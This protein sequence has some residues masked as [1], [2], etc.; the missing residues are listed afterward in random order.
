MTTPLPPKYGFIAPEIDTKQYVLGQG[1]VPFKVLRRDGNWKIG[2]PV[3]E[4]QARE[5]D[6]YNCTSFNTLNQIEQYMFVAFGETVNYSDRWLGIISG[7]KPPGNDP[8]VV[9]EAIREFGLIPEEMLPFSG[10]IAN[11]D[12]YYSFKGAN[13]EECREAGRRWKAKYRLYHEWVFDMSQPQAEKEHNMKVALKYSPLAIAVYAWELG[14]KNIYISAGQPNHWTSLYAI[15][16]HLEVF[17]SYDPFEKLVSQNIFYC[18]R[19]HIEKV[20]AEVKIKKPSFCQNFINSIR[21]CFRKPVL[22]Y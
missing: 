3:K 14:E 20:L 16:N 9:Y 22:D 21:N 4:F 6:T 2:L 11:V 8:Q 7:T 17:D 13:E 10:D 5:F 1:K 18:K 12:E 19:I 15:G